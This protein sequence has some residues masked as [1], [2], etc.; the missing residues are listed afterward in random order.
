MS[1]RRGRPPVTDRPTLSE[2][3]LLSLT[4]AQK[5]KLLARG[6]AKWVRGLIDKSE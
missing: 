2:R 1:K 5:A 3:F 6:G 4:P